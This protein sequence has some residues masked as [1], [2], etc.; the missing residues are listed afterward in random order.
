[1]IDI[2][3]LF[4]LYKLEKN[5][6]SK[7]H[8]DLISLKEEFNN[9]DIKKKIYIDKIINLYSIIISIYKIDEIKLFLD[10]KKI[11]YEIYTENVHPKNYLINKKYNFVKDI[12][13][14]FFGDVYLFK[15]KDIFYACKIDELKNFENIDEYITRK[16][17]E[18]KLL[19]TVGINNI[20]PKIYNN[21]YIIV[22]NKLYNILIMEYIDGKTLADYL[23]TETYTENKINKIKKLINKK[24]NKLHKLNIIHGDLHLNNIMIVE[25]NNKIN[26]FIIDL[27]LSG[28]TNNKISELKKNNYN[29][30]KYVNMHNKTHIK[31]DELIIY[32]L[33]KNKKIK[34]IF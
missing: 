19:N 28:K 7:K 16:N 18:Y 22:N 2:K 14:G 9:L 12:G 29:I 26:I 5:N 6:L 13:S 25:K 20:G 27:G 17:N 24:I 31:E 33:Y 1:M 21:H 34:F 30:M 23:A 3:K 4:G 8:N 32:K 15:K 11:K 10:K